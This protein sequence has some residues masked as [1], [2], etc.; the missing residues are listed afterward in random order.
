MI[1]SNPFDK[2]IGQTD[3]FVLRKRTQH[4]SHITVLACRVKQQDVRPLTNTYD[5]HGGQ[6]GL[7]CAIN[8]L[9]Q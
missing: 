7:S 4:P 2:S 3:S 8:L 1:I 5:T 6:F 9:L